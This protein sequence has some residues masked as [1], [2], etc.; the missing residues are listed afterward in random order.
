MQM[1]TFS[2]E[3]KA[4]CVVRLQSSRYRLFL[5]GASEKLTK[6][7][8]HVVSKNPD[9]KQ[10][11]DSEF[12]TKAI[13]EVTKDNISRTTIFYANQMLWTIA[14][15]HR[16]FESWPAGTSTLAMKSHTMIS[17]AT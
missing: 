7:T 13:D 8:R 14:L 10:N 4:T 5:K 1:I 11:T 12:E 17:L 15:C 3:R 2:S 9:H 16:H 6:C